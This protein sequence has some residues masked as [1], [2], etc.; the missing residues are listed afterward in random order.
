MSGEETTPDT[1]NSGSVEPQ[2]PQA[3]ENWEQRFKDNQTA[4]HESQQKLKAEQAIWDDEDALLERLGERYPDW[5]MGDDSD[6]TEDSTT[7]Q[8][9]PAPA[10]DPR[11]DAALA[12]LEGLQAD[13]AERDY[14][15]DLST[16]LAGRK[17]GDGGEEFIRAMTERG[18][19]TRKALEGAVEKWFGLFPAEEKAPEKKRVSHVIAAGKMT[20]DGKPDWS[21]MTEDEIDR[22]MAA[23]VVARS[24]Q[25]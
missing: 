19:D 22:F 18:G 2:A 3:A 1:G 4:F 15:N 7:T 8:E 14:Q 23:E 9:S 20:E 16:I 13:K 12:T 21:Q 10:H 17:V 6:T 5:L 11:V 25:T 24:Q